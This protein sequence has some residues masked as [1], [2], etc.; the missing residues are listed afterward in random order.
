MR[1]KNHPRTIVYVYVD[2]RVETLFTTEPT[3]F[4]TAIKFGLIEGAARA[5]VKSI[6]KNI[7]PG[8]Y[9]ATLT[10]FE[11]FKRNA[12]FELKPV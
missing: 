4:R 11:L 7:D 2:G 5:H 9:E 1:I 8:R 12:H 6:A 3:S 10:K